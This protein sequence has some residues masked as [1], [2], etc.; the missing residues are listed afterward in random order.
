MQLTVI[1]LN[2]FHFLQLRFSF[3][4]VVFI[5]N[6][7]FLIAFFQLGVSLSIVFLLL[8]CVL[9]SAYLFSTTSIL[10]NG[11]IWTIFLLPICVIL[12]MFPLLNCVS[13]SR[14]FPFNLSPSQM[15]HISCVILLNCVFTFWTASFPLR[16]SFSSASSQLRPPSRI[17]SSGYI[18]FSTAPFQVC[19]SFPIVS[20]PLHPINCVSPSQMC[21]FNCVSPSLVCHMNWVS[22]SKRCFPFSVVLFQL[23]EQTFRGFFTPKNYIL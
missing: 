4:I 15:Y 13:P 7:V 21:P 8:K 14:C 17:R 20:S 19:F 22:P 9:A 23:Y 12:T 16:L 11:V 1:F 10:L 6:R 3:S 5:L 18:S 2:Q